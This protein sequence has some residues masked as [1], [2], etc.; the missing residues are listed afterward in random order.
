MFVPLINR[1]MN[2]SCAQFIDNTPMSYADDPYFHKP[3][4]IDE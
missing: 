1:G 2:H 3:S 4:R